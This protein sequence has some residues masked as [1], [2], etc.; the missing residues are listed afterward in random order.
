M[1]GPGWNELSGLR[2]QTCRNGR[3]RWQAVRC[4]VA[5]SLPPALV[6][7]WMCKGVVRT[8]CVEGAHPDVP[9]WKARVARETKRGY[10]MLL[11]IFA[12][13]FDLGQKSHK[14]LAQF[15]NKKSQMLRKLCNS[16]NFSSSA[17]LLLL[18]FRIVKE[19]GKLSFYGSCASGMLRCFL[20][21][22][23]LSLKGTIWKKLW[24]H[25]WLEDIWVRTQCL[26]SKANLML[27][28][29]T[30]CSFLTKFLQLSNPIDDGWLRICL[31]LLLISTF[32]VRISFM[33]HLSVFHM[34]D[35]TIP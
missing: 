19:L 20:R 2:T 3:P 13:A 11:L 29:R 4:D 6:N 25:N 23:S 32:W 24:P 16:R 1:E 33:F 17:E 31:N 34:L 15:P 9:K 12:C 21:A 7:I 8:N 22:T 28:Q 14:S 27:F 10:R 30:S 35:E 18:A 5:W 26:S